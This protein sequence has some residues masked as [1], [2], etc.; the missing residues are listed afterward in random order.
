MRNILRHMPFVIGEYTKRVH[1]PPSCQTNQGIIGILHGR[2]SRAWRSVVFLFL[3]FPG[4]TSERLIEV[5]V[6]FL[7]LKDNKWYQVWHKTRGCD[8]QYGGRMGDA[9]HLYTLYLK[10]ADPILWQE[11]NIL[12]WMVVYNQIKNVICTSNAVLLYNM[13]EIDRPNY[14]REMWNCFPCSIFY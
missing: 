7:L 11:M 14:P 8:G 12:S 6:E 1:R 13:V 2:K 10:G 4:W 3:L 9:E 5:K